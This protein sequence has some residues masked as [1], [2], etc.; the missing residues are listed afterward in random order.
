MAPSSDRVL[1]LTSRLARLRRSIRFLFALDGGGRLVLAAAAFVA[2]TFA[3]DWTFHLP[4]G[5]RLALLAAGLGLLLW[6]LVRRILRPLA[7][8]LTDDD[9]GI[10]VERRFPG[11]NDRLISALQLARDPGA[12][13]GRVPG[14]EFNS[15]ELVQALVEEAAG[16]VEGVDWGR[17]LVRRRVG[18]VAAGAALAAASL[19]AAGLASPLYASIYFHRILGGDRRWPRR[20]H[21]KVLDFV[22]G[23]RVIARGDDLTIA[24]EYDGLEPSRVLLRYEFRSGERGTERMGPLPGRRFQYTFPR[25]PGPFEFTVAGGDDVTEPHVV[26]TLDPPALEAMAVFYEYPAYLH[27]PNTP[28]DRPESSGNVTAPFHT[29]V[30]FEALSTED[31]R[32]AT[33]VLGSR[34]REKTSGLE[35]GPATDGRPRRLTGTFEVSESFAEY[36]LRLLA[37]NG[38]V[39]RDP[40]RFAVRGLEDRLPEITVLEPPGDELVSGLCERPLEIET[41]DDHGIARI[42]LEYRVLA[43]QKEKARDWT[44]EVFGGRQNSGDYGETLIRSR[45]VLDLGP[46]GLQAGDHV[47]LRFRAEDYKDIGPPHIRTTR[48]YRFSVVPLGTLEKD[49]QDAIEKIKQVLRGQK[50]RQE[51]AWARTGALID[52]LGRVDPLSPEQQGELRQSGLEQTDLASRL[53]AARRDLRWVLRRG[54]YNK[55]YNE[56]AV[57][58]LQGAVDALGNCVGDPGEASRPGICREAAARLDQAARARGADA[59]VSLLREVRTLQSAVAVEIQKAIDFL[60][61]WSSYQEVI[62]LTREILEMQKRVNEKIKSGP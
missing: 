42:A 31:L 55:V 36:S 16:A 15:P 46:M 27:R 19:A 24:V 50:L 30:R 38:L 58:K 39:N 49:L 11:L 23:R 2:A 54:V 59:R 9:L 45:R 22:D 25:V 29:R 21:L 34:G 47:E 61:K 17:I 28:P 20:T 26:E 1:P 35:V 14:G 60:D 4:A 13:P 57:A 18:W 33:L 12:G 53:D 7:V 52:R 3:V 32:S 5:A 8:P 6:I 48:V 51:A 44:A 43:Q 62:R 37:R 56:T 40:I 41:R 10:L